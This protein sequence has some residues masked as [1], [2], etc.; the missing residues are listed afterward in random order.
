MMKLDELI[1]ALK[2]E[3]PEEAIN[4]A[5]S[6]VLVKET[7]NDV[8]NAMNQKMSQAYIARNFDK[9]RAYMNM[10]ETFHQFETRLE[11]IINELDVDNM[12]FNPDESDEDET[13]KHPARNYSQYEV[14]SNVEHT[15]YENL[16]HIRPYGF[17]I[18]EHH[19]VKVK[20]WKEM[21]VKTC[22]FLIAIDEEKFLNFENVGYMNG[23]KNKYFSIDPR[24]LRK[25][26]KVANK[27]YVE[28][29]MSSNSIRNL[30]IKLLKEYNFKV[31]EFKVYFRADYTAL[32]S[33]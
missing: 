29:N 19:I 12:D 20:T 27:I 33:K 9:S 8:M 26:E 6:L 28:T 3:F 22:E 30:L 23:K 2:Q 24:L 13:T 21:L 15:L 10:A 5:E 31:N 1:T 4:L 16:T 14:D 18:N 25:P 17:K 32:N 11:E 7:I